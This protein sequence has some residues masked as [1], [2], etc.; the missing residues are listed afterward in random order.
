MIDYT[1]E[2]KQ[3]VNSAVEKLKKDLMD[4]KWGV[5]SVIDAKKILAV[6]AEDALKKIIDMQQV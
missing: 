5:L 3:N 1:K 6:E 2:S 4:N